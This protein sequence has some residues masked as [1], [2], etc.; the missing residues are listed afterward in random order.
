MNVIDRAVWS[1]DVIKEF[2]YLLYSQEAMKCSQLMNRLGV[3]SQSD[4]ACFE[5]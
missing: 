5:E 1:V 2:A 3:Y 4:L